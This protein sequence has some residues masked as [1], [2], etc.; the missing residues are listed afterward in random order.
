MAG[1]SL[2]FARLSAAIPEHAANVPMQCFSQHASWIW[3]RVVLRFSFCGPAEIPIELE[4]TSV[5]R[6]GR[7]AT[8]ST[9]QYKYLPKPELT[10]TC[11]ARSR[12]RSARSVMGNTAR[13]GAPVSENGSETVFLVYYH[14]IASVYAAYGCASGCASPRRHNI[15]PIA[16][17]HNPV[18]YIFVL[19]KFF[20]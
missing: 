2:H 16:R 11:N 19:L 4:L 17:S 8:A 10:A 5:C 13:S 20:T 7:Q 14:L 18:I 9:R 15:D 12:L 1:Y 3:T 6:G